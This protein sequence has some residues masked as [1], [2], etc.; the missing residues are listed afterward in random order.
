M[1]FTELFEDPLEEIT[2]RGFLKGVGAA[3][4]GFAPKAG[5]LE[6]DLPP[7]PIPKEKPKPEIN[8]IH[9]KMIDKITDKYDIDDEFA[10]QV[11]ELAHKHQKP[12]FP[13]AKDIL[14]IIGVES[15]FDPDAVS[16]LRQDPA[17]G[18]MQVRPGVW[19]IDRSTL[20]GDIE[21]QI[22][23][24]SDIL[25]QY[26]QKLKNKNAALASYN[27][28]LTQ[29]RSGNTADNYVKKYHNELRLYTG[30]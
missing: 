16:G 19:N 20:Q 2:R 22:A 14:A 7:S 11:V 25:H 3:G 15:S 17:V 26:Y 9:Q 8:P 10:Q 4:L 24:G 13:T 12:G 1:K 29:Y 5:G 28:G 27:V 21:K 30:M 23:T 18:L 6:K